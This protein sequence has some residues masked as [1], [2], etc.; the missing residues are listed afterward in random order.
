MGNSDVHLEDQ[1]GTPQTV[2]YAEELGVEAVLAGIRAG[3]SWIAESAQVNLSFT[4][5]VSDRSSQIG[6]RMDAGSE[7]I[8]LLVAVN[9]VP[10]GVV[11]LHTQRGR[12]HQETLPSD[13][14]ATVE[15][16]THADESGFVRV[17]VRHPDGN[18][19]ALTNPIILF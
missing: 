18:M 5:S 2:V 1:M 16:E 9:G 19:A 8:R 15:W 7:P 12:A 10:S 4:A 6:E 13:G 14:T 17:E 11:S 3:H